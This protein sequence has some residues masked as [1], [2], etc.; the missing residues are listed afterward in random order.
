MAIDR[1]YRALVEERLAAVCELKTRAMF[2]GLGIYA[3]DKF[4][5][6]A[7]DGKLYFKVDDS[8]RADFEARGM[9]PFVPWDGAP[10][11]GYWELPPGVIDD[12]SELTVWVDKAVG[13]AERAKRK[14]RS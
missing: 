8:N 3:G 12:P 14:K 10:P 11:M 5:A 7:D 13:V 1:A 4:F 2:G 6:L 9:G